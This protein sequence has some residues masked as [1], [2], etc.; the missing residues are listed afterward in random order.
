[1]LELRKLEADSPGSNF[2]NVALAEVC[3]IIIDRYKPVWE[4]KL[5]TVSLD[6]EAV[7]RADHA[8]MLRIIDNFF[9]NA[10]DNTP[11]GGSISIRMLDDTLEVYNSG[12]YIPKNKVEEIWLPF[13]KGDTARGC[14]KGTGLGLAIARTILELHKFSYGA[15]NSE[16]GV[17]FWFRF[18]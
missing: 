13:K 11:A 5:I 1:M 8:L 15:K 6:G 9:V 14:S 10:L 12:S 4:E 17:T 2:E 3:K 16:D 7:I 18:R